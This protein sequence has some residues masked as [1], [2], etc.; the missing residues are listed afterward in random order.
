MLPLIPSPR[1]VPID[2]GSPLWKPDNIPEE[3]LIPRGPELRIAE[4]IQQVIDD[5][6]NQ[7][8]RSKNLVSKPKNPERTYKK[9]EVWSQAQIDQALEES[10]H[11]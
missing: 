6:N 5:M 4:N 9:S 11:I 2:K 3:P 10:I 8:D 7:Q 1:I